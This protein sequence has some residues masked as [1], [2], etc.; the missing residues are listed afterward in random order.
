[1]SWTPRYKH[2][3]QIHSPSGSGYDDCWPAS[4]TRYLYEN[5]TF[6][7]A[8]DPVQ[9]LAEVALVTRG[10]PDAPD[11]APVDFSQAEH[12]MAHYGLKFVWTTSFAQAS[13]AAWSIVYVNGIRLSP[14]QY[15]SS[16]FGG[17]DI[18]DHFI[19]WLP[20]W[21]GSANW[22]NDPLAY[23]NGQQDC[24]YTSESVAY[25]FGGAYMLP[26]TNNGE[27]SPVLVRA[28]SK[29]SLKAA[30]S[31]T[32]TGVATIPALGQCLDLSVRVTANKQEW[33]K[34]EW[35]SSKSGCHLGYVLSDNIAVFH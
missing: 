27:N 15:P 26:T 7:V 20:K 10:T 11:N 1:M 29:C 21:G 5:K 12:S 9:A 31:H 14:A 32:S 30:P 17:E 13:A 35:C 33:A 28:K 25:A 3:S 24:V 6:S 2:V 16:W 22:F 23:N 19:L 34:V 18:F 4:L 8:K